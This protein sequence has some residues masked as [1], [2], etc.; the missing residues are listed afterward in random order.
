MTSSPEQAY[1]SD[2]SQSLQ[3]QLKVTAKV[4]IAI[5]VLAAVVLLGTLFYLLSGQPQQSYY[6]A[7]QALT[8]TQDQL[9]LAMILGGALIVSVAGLLTWFITLYS[10]ARIAGPLYRFS[11][12]IELEIKHGPVSIISLR[13]GDPFQDL[14][15]KLNHTVEGLGQYYDDQHDLLDEMYRILEVGSEQYGKQNN[16]QKINNL[17]LQL[18]EA[19]NK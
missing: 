12:N 5:S 19:V 13:K 11:Q 14:S 10:S 2:L 17:L 6:Q 18:K 9:V 8:K 4:A 15:L 7:L 1:E 16:N 3:L